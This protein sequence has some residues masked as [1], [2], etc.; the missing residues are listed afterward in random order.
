MNKLNF[1]GSFLLFVVI[2]LFSIGQVAVGQWRDH[3][4]YSYGER[5]VLAGNHVYLVTNVGLLKYNKQSG[6][7]EKM[8]KN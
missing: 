4:P 1:L 8:T 3:L 7:T 5:I 6:E 2:S